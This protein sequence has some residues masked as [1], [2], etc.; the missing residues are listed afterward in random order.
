MD[1]LWNYWKNFKK[2][3]NIFTVMEVKMSLGV[4]T[5]SKNGAEM[6][7]EWIKNLRKEF[8]KWMN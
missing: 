8:A 6:Q 5:M 3:K 2:I 7:K 4:N 1:Y